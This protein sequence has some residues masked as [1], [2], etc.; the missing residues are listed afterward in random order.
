M[1]EAEESVL[2]DTSSSSLI[3]SS[4]S[5]ISESLKYLSLDSIVSEDRSVK[6]GAGDGAGDGMD[7]FFF[8]RIFCLRDDSFVP[9]FEGGEDGDNE[10]LENCLFERDTN[11]FKELL[12]AG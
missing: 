7:N 11:D 3:R 10:E 12:M 1:M 8:A 2:W 6:D 4:S 5:E 9:T